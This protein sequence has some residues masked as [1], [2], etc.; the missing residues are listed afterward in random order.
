MEGFPGVPKLVQEEEA[1]FVSFLPQELELSF[2]YA[3]SILRDPDLRL[4]RGGFDYDP[5]VSL[6]PTPGHTPGHQSVVV[7][8][9][10]GTYILAGDATWPG[11]ERG[12]LPPR[13]A[14]D[15][16]QARRSFRALSE[17]GEPLL[18]SHDPGVMNL[19]RVG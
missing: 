15:A 11:S 1:A 14:I 6:I 2:Q 18:A 8:T 4:V 17:R 5:F 19:G 12:L 10:A 16:E 9:G 3:S 7:K 13:K